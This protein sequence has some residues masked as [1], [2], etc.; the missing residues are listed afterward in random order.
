MLFIRTF[1]SKWQLRV[2]FY[3]N[4]T[5]LRSGSCYRKSVGGLSVACL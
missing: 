2:N 4:V 3:P 5:M 1:E